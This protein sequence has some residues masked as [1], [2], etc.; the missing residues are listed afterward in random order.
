MMPAASSSAASKCFATSIGERSSEALVFRVV[1]V[2]LTGE[3]AP[4]DGAF[5]KE[6]WQARRDS[7]PQPAVLETAALPIELLAYYRALT[8]PQRSARNYGADRQPIR[9][10]TL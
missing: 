3:V 5:E 1:T 4:Q 10:V 8:P 2:P 7:N 6:K 9:A